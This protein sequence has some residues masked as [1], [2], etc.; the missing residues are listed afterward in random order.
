MLPV[1]ATQLQEVAQQV[2]QAVVGVC[3][4]FQGM[5]ARARKAA[6]RLP[7]AKDA[8]DNGS[9]SGTEGINGL[10]SSTRETMG[11]LLQR[12]EQSST[13]SSL[14]VERM[15]A[16]EEHIGGLDRILHEVDEIAARSAS[17][18]STARSKRLGWETRGPRSPWWLRKRRKSPALHGLEPDHPQHHGDGFGRH[19]A[20]MEL[21]RHAAADTQEAA[22]SRDEVDRRWTPW[23]L[24]EEMQRTIEQTQLESDQ[25]AR[26][27]SAAV[28]AMQFQDSVSHR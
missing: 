22:L 18:H 11:S 6:S 2:E 1:L 21:R 5:A 28:M 15:Q 4:N 8:S 3:G 20:Y 10:I 7:L 26:D 24:H 17:W 12:I 27:I 13:F 25:L 23:H 9:R 14:T 19:P 16:V